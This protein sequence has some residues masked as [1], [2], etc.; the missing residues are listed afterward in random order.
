MSIKIAVTISQASRTGKLE[1]RML[2][3]D[4]GGISF[5]DKDAFVE[6]EGYT[7]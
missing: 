6:I 7:T 1:Q 5:V 4:A 3:R 2:D